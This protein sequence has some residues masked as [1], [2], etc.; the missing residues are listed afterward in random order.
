[1]TCTHPNLMLHQNTHL[2]KF[3]TIS[4]ASLQPYIKAGLAVEASDVGIM[5]ELEWGAKQF[6]AFLRRL[7]PALFDYFD[8]TTPGFKA[9][10]D[11]PDTSGMKRI[12]YSLP[13][14]LLQK[15][16]RRYN[17]VDST[18]PNG[19]KYKEFL[20]GDG[21]NSGFRAKGIFIGRLPC[22]TI[23]W[24][25]L[26]KSL[27][28]VTKSPIPQAVLDE[29]FSPSS[30]PV[31]P[32]GDTTSHPTPDGQGKRRRSG[33]FTTNQSLACILN[34]PVRDSISVSSDSSEAS[35]GGLNKALDDAIASVEDEETDTEVVEILSKPPKKR[36]RG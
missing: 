21:S 17:V 10:P 12:E 2:F 25:A 34:Y 35:Q 30:A 29:W 16:Y 13:Y 28:Q 11:E 5:F 20:S 27:S 32:I 36:I 14:V 7:F 4:P 9:I 8:T 31:I 1:M 18:H 23:S 26:T 33:E 19:A 24:E 15:D 22:L 6:N 3:P